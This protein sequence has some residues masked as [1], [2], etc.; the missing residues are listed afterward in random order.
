MFKNQLRKYRLGNVNASRKSE[1]DEKLNGT[2]VWDAD[3]EGYY[4]SSR[5]NE[6]I[7]S[8]SLIHF[9]GQM[10]GRF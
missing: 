7:E 10:T 2:K 6:Q 4:S 8:E 3:K 9:A 5:K 1:K